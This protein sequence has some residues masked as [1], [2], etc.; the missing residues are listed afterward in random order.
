[1]LCCA[2]KFL[3]NTSQAWDDDGG[4]SLLETTAFLAVAMVMLGFMVNTAYF[5]ISYYSLNE[6]AAAAAAYAS[7]G[8]T[9]I[10]GSP[11][12]PTPNQV[13]ALAVN[14][15]QNL[16]VA[17]G[18]TP[19]SVSLCTSANNT[20]AP[21]CSGSVGSSAMTD[22]EAGNDGVSAPQFQTVSVSV[23]Y[24]I[25]P[26]ISG[27]VIGFSLLPFSYPQTFQR[28]FYMRVIN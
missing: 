7:Q 10:S 2:K 14:D 21:Q 17:L 28:T 27:S 15:V 16:V 3:K 9:Y 8:K 12:L 18:G 19:P 1:L 6:A 11:N 20:P 5:V 25:K 4:Q 13:T 24:T 22:P 26:L 23:S